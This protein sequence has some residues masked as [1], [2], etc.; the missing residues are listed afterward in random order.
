[1]TVCACVCVPGVVARSRPAP[2]ERGKK[3]LLRILELAAPPVQL[4]WNTGLRRPARLLA[5]PHA[6]K[7]LRRFVHVRC[8][9]LAEAERQQV[10]PDE[11]ADRLIYF[12]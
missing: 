3:S 10:D 6:G 11:S 9:S 1:M 2:A 5:A 7:Q 4:S 12:T 8:G